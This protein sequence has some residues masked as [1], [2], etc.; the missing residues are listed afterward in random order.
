MADNKAMVMNI[1]Q[2]L[3]TG[4]VARALGYFDDDIEWIEA[5][6]F[7]YGGTYRGPGEIVEGVFRK[8]GTEWDNWKTVPAEFIA[9]GDTVVVIGEYSGTYL[10]SGKS[11][12]AP[13]VHVWKLGDGKVTGFEQ[14]TDTL[15]VDR[16]IN[17][18]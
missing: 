6:G 5:A 1:Y 3:A 14:H 9:D 16:A 11:F 15:I 4:D 13:Y 8:L 7:P 18:G 17:A 10:A 2:A 12:A